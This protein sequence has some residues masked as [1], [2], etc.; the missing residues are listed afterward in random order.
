MREPGLGL[1]AGLE[2]DL[3]S[4]SVEQLDGPLGVAEREVQA[5]EV[6]QQ[7]AD[8]RA[9]LELLVVAARP[10]RVRPREQPVALAL[11]DERAWKYACA[12][13][14]RSPADSA[15]SSAR[16]TSSRA[17]CQSRWRR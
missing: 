9:V 12:G 2:R 7:P 10:L 3:G 13:A 14:R 6:V 5:A 16:S 8:V 15:S 4:A 1:V 17:A 11:G